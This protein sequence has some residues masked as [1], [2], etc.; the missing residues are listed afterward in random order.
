MKGPKALFERDTLINNTIR[1]IIEIV[2]K[3]EIRKR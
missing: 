1:K 3:K 2:G